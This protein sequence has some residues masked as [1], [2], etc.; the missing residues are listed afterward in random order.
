MDKVQFFY[1]LQFATLFILSLAANT[2]FADFP[3]LASLIAND[4]YLPR[5]LTSVGDR[6]VF[7]NGIVALAFM[8]SLLIIVFDAREHNLLPL[9]AVGVFISFTLSQSGMVVHWMRQRHTEGF[10]PGFGWYFRIGM[11]AF[12]AFSTFIVMLILI[13]TKFMEGAWLVLVA[14]PVFIFMFLK[15]HAH[16]NMVAKSLTLDGCVPGPLHIRTQDRTHAPTVV[17]LNSLN[18]SSLQALEYALHTPRTMCGRA[19][20]RPARRRLSG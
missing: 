13:V 14:I 7:S 16:Y 15:V 20:L 9:Y 6:L 11:N 18:R 2:A 1:Y 3:R 17:L 8:A 12:G 10:K 19:R 4:R 5:Q